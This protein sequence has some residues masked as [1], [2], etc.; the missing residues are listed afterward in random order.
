MKILGIVADDSDPKH[1]NIKNQITR[2]AFRLNL[3]P[4]G[5]RDIETRI[6]QALLGPENQQR[7]LTDPDIC[8][9]NDDLMTP[10]EYRRWIRQAGLDKHPAFWVNIMR[11]WM[12]NAVARHPQTPAG[13]V[14]TGLYSADQAS[15]IRNQGGR[16]WHITDWNYTDQIGKA[17]GIP[18]KPQDTRIGTNATDETI[19]GL[20]SEL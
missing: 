17:G 2:H 7:V 3:H 1:Q 12:Y 5:F 13:Y 20:L 6:V 9:P 19:T 18:I 4:L 16:I 14:I 11:I 10:N 15:W 8:V